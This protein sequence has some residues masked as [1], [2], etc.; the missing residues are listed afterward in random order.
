MP[1]DAGVAPSG[2]LRQDLGTLEVTE[3]VF[4]DLVRKVARDV[5]GVAGLG[6]P[7]GLF[8]RSSVADAV[9]VERGE[10]EVAFSIALTVC[11][12]VRI[13]ELVEELRAR[14]KATVENIT[15]YRVRAIH[16]TVEHILPPEEGPRKP[17]DGTVVP[18]PLPGQE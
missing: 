4:R 17:P 2:V 14:V 18:P 10:G 5:P 8:R 6:R 12:D 13:P 15:G 11:Y 1:E 9:Q 16:I 3:D 7:S